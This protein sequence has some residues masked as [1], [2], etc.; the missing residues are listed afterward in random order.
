MFFVL[1]KSIIKFPD[2]YGFKLCCHID[3]WVG[4]S[5]VV[6]GSKTLNRVT[7]GARVQGNFFK[8]LWQ[9]FCNFLKVA[10]ILLFGE[11]VGVRL[12]LFPGVE[13]EASWI[14]ALRLV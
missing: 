3:G 14:P 13:T 6:R 12:V 9:G 10:L 5:K 1:F 2:R 8:H 11:E 4:N 7:F